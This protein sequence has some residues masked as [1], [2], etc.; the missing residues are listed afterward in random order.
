MSRL[1]RLSAA[2]QRA[3]LTQI[4][5]G[6]LRAEQAAAQRA[7]ST[8]VCWSCGTPITSGFDPVDGR[9]VECRSG[10]FVTT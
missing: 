9:C 3:T 8:S 10:Q 5:A 6:V 4:A 1:N 2:V 7:A